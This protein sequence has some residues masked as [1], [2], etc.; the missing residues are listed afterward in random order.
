[1]K[2]A[3]FGDIHGQVFQML[4]TALYW[5]RKT[6]TQLE[7]IVQVGDFGAFPD[8]ESIQQDKAAW[9][10]AQKNPAELDFSCLLGVKEGSLADSLKLA[11]QELRRP[12]YFIRGNHD[13]VEWL[14]EVRNGRP[15]ASESTAVDAFDLFH[16]VS[17]G[18]VL[19][20][21]DLTIG[22]LGG[23]ENPEQRPQ[24]VFNEAAYKSL[25][26]LPCGMLDVLVTHEPPY[27]VS[28]GYGGQVQG[29]AKITT[30]L[31][32]IAPRY[33]IAGHL[34]HVIG[35]RQFGTTT[36][37][38]LNVLF[39]ARSERRCVEPGSLVIL[40]TTLN[41]LDLIT[42]DWLAGITQDFSFENRAILK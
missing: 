1:M 24:D 38:G 11:R 32:A 9:R 41:T 12:I 10:F 2:I 39:N 22:F 42:D 29:S 37:L 34:H 40:D 19:Q 33:L 8:L 3:F 28:T 21:G 36:Y 16:Y 14:E 26:A 27:G 17:D 6:D 15:I 20:F 18:S 35:P 5:Q 31:E 23:I 7:Y 25:L 13:D 4:A 30:L